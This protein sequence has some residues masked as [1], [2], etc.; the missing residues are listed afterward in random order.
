MAAPAIVSGL[1]SA[2]AALNLASGS[3]AV[4]AASATLVGAATA[5]TAVIGESSLGDA[6]R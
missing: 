5:H 3:A 1:S 2:L 4:A 6:K